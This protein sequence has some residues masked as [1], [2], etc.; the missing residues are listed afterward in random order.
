[1][2]NSDFEALIEQIRGTTEEPGLT[3]EQAKKLADAM[4]QGYGDVVKD[5]WEKNEAAR[6]GDPKGD[7]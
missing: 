6:Y 5:L 4:S 2:T 3:A 1:M 7:D